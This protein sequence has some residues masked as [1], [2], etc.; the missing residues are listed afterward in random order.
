M[1]FIMH[2]LTLYSWPYFVSAFENVI[3]IV[4][5]THFEFMLLRGQAQILLRWCFL[6]SPDLVW[7]EN[8]VKLL[9]I[10][11]W[12]YI[13]LSGPVRARIGPQRYRRRTETDLAGAEK[14]S[15]WSEER[16]SGIRRWRRDRRSCGSLPP[17]PRWRWYLNAR[18]VVWGGRGTFKW[19]KD[20]SG[21]RRCDAGFPDR[22]R[23]RRTV[24]LRRRVCI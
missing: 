8:G 7:P 13:L 3:F 15:R 9:G 6:W 17:W 10:I 18:L 2:N 24:P 19:T 21:F 22:P 4:D 11:S 14:S 5:L 16:K 12:A 1:G 20:Q 23:S